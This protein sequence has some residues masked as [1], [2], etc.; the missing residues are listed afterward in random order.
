[1]LARTH[2]H[3][4]DLIVRAHALAHYRRYERGA[5]QMLA[6]ARQLARHE[7]AVHAAADAYK[8]RIKVVVKHAFALGKKHLPHAE[9]V[10]TAVGAE[11]K[12]SMPRVLLQTMKAGG[13]A[14]LS[15]LP[16]VSLK[17]AEE[18]RFLRHELV[19]KFDATNQDAIDWADEHAADL[20][21]S[22]SETTRDRIREAIVMQEATGEDAT[23]RIAA[24]V[25]DDRAEVIARTESMTAANEGQRQ[26]WDQ[27]VDAGL[28]PQDATRVWIAAADPCPE[29][30]DLDGEEVALDEEYPNDGGDGPPLH[31]NCRC[32][33]GIVAA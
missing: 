9:A 2:R 8:D 7:T 28:L 22:V 26:S 6:Q 20:V 1:M 3:V 31:P 19:M 33:E 29:C 18:H 10:A 21:T 5:E 11:L 16:S 15:M 14:A 12:K 30:E 13:D 4:A 24:V 25:G 17:A 27:A 23:D 32:T